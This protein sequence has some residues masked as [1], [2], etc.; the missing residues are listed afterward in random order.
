[1]CILEKPIAA[2]FNSL[3][4]SILYYQHMKKLLFIFIISCINA[5]CQN[6]DNFSDIKNLPNLVSETSG[7]ET[8]SATKG[9]WT[10]NDSGNSNEIFLINDKG[11]LK[12]VVKVTNAKNKDWE[13]LASDGN[14]ML[15]IGDFG[16]NGNLRR[17]LTIYAVNVDSIKNKEVK[18][19]KTT[20]VY[21]DQ[22]KFPPKKKDRNFDSEAFIYFN[23]YF[24]IFS[25]N[26]STK[27]DGTTKLYKIPAE[28]GVQ[29]ARFIGEFKVCQ[30]IKNCQ[31]TGADISND[32]KKLVLLMHDK[33]LLFSNFESDAFFRGETEYIQ[34]KHNSQKEAICFSEST[35]FITDEKRKVTGG[36]LY[37]VRKNLL[38][39]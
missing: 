20:F 28:E 25:K 35:V 33:I 23:N 10:I 12:K 37:K 13:A 18:A 36:N 34:L 29:V 5:S 27:F 24:Y 6:L 3:L 32:G 17:D 14:S 4:L 9:I 8:L 21:E 31:I 26:R 16:N 19:F 22:M 1:M 2:F 30:N 11:K 38:N 7:I 39:N 15:Y